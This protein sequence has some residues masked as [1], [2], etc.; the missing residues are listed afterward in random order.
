NGFG[1]VGAGQCFPTGPATPPARRLYR[2]IELLARK[3]VGDKLWLQTSYVYSSLRGNYDGGINEGFQ[4][5]TPGL[6]LDFDQPP[7]WH[8]SYGRLFLDRPHRFRFDGFWTTP[9]GP[10]I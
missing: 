6:N 7:L 5:T 8:N 1:D 10:S 3:S 2:G 4:Q 9:L